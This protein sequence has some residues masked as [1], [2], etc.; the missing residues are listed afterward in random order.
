MKNKT[1]NATVFALVCSAI[2]LLATIFLVNPTKAPAEEAVNDRDFQ[3]VTAL[4]M[5]GSEGLYILDKRSGLI[6][7]FLYEPG[8]GLQHKGTSPASAAFG[9][10]T[11]R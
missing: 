10:G 2:A 4:V 7:V 8:R 3:V 5:N 1:N 11:Q 6:A 9:G